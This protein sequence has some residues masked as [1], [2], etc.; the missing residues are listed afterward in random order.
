MAKD[1]NDHHDG[2]TSVV[3]GRLLMSRQQRCAVG[4]LVSCVGCGVEFGSC[5]LVVQSGQQP[6]GPPSAIPGSPLTPDGTKHTN[7][8]L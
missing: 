1:G 5:A 4:F 7:Y 6:C 2:S 8:G 3:L